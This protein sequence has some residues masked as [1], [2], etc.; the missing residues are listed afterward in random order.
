ME[1]CSRLLAAS[2]LLL[3]LESGAL[4][5]ALPWERE[6]SE[7]LVRLSARQADERQSVCPGYSPLSPETSKREGCVTGGRLGSVN[8]E[9][10]L[11]LGSDVDLRSCG[12]PEYPDFK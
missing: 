4:L 9:Q 2:L 6:S 7:Q 3:S 11:G 1:Q 5:L 8:H 12:F 10:A